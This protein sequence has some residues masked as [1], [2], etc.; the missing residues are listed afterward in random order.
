MDTTAEIIIA[1]QSNGP[2]GTLYMEFDEDTLTMTPAAA[3]REV[4]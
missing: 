4:E 2:T 1:K 3:F